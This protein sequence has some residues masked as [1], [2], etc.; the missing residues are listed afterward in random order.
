MKRLNAYG[1]IKVAFLIFALVAV[2]LIVTTAN[3]FTNVMD[4]KVNIPRNVWI[5][6]VNIPKIDNA[7]ESATISV[8]FNVTNPTN[9]D[10]YIYDINYKL[11][12]ND[13]EN[14]MN[15]ERPETWDDW[16]VGL[17]GFTVSTEEAI[18]VPSRTHVTISANLTVTGDTIFMEHLNVTDNFGN[19]HPRIIATMR[20]TFKDIDIKEIVYGIY[21]YS[22]SG[23]SPEPSED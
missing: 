21:F 7:S 16:A 1:I 10:I 20:Y 11:Y 5:E 3:T 12:M 4:A 19:Y 15:P 9:I 2:V 23:I 14:P 13:F 8:I 18:R 17:G 6:G 22:E